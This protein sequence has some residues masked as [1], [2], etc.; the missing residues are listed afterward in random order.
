M[1]L[2]KILNV[3][4]TVHNIIKAF[5]PVKHIRYIQFSVNTENFIVK[6]CAINSRTVFFLLLIMEC[7]HCAESL[8]NFT[9]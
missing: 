3:L 7:T 4:D 6:E 2:S 5:I 1:F 9:S 8:S